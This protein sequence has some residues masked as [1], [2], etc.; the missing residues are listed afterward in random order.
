[1]ASGDAFRTVAELIDNDED[2]GVE[3][4]SSARWDIREA[5]PSK[6]IE[7]AVVKTVAAFL[8]TDGGTLRLGIGPYSGVVGRERVD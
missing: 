4:K 3:F 1:M 7:D 5:Q 6:L 8:N 2:Y